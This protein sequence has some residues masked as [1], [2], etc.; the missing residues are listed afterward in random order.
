M[1]CQKR[2][3]TESESILMWSN[4]RNELKF[5][6]SF[7]FSIDKSNS[8][9]ERIVNL[10][11]GHD[12]RQMLQLLIL[13]LS[14][15]YAVTDSVIPEQISYFDGSV[16]ETLTL[17]YMYENELDKHPHFSILFSGGPFLFSD[18][19]FDSTM[20]GCGV[21]AELRRYKSRESYCYFVSGISGTELKWSTNGEIIESIY[22][23]FKFG[24]KWNLRESGVQLDLEPSLGA[25]MQVEN[26]EDADWEFE[27]EPYVIFELGLMMH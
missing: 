6:R 16:I 12:R 21:E 24:W 3:A 19:Y 13:L 15:G 23:G 10:P 18:T 4:A 2:E 14:N 27:P 1:G 17:S 11:R 5:W 20:W 26:G 22:T 25:G 8:S 9:I 7:W